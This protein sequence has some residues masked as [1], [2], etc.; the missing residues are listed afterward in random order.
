MSIFRSIKRR[1]GDQGRRK[2]LLLGLLQGL[3][4]SA[5]AMTAVAAPG[6]A[7]RAAGP[8]CTGFWGLS[9]FSASATTAP[10]GSGI[11]LTARTNCD[12]GSVNALVQIVDNTNGNIPGKCRTGTSCSV[13][14]TG[15]G[16][17]THSFAAYLY[18]WNGSSWNALGHTQP[19]YLTWEAPPNNFT[20]SLSGPSLIAY[21]GGPATY[22]ATANQD[23]GPTPYWI[24]I[25][26]AT[27]STRLGYCSSGSTCSVSFT[28]SFAPGDELVAF[29]SSFSSSFLPTGIQASSNMLATVQQQLVT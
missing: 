29:V 20:V 10:V 23:V 25:F 4:I 3:M 17:L 26:D 5:L 27:T 11:T 14:T 22:T 12:I 7:A 1:P 13:T 21:H 28:P 2:A 15:L 19:I 9:G 8:A 18:I 24:E 6:H 16:A